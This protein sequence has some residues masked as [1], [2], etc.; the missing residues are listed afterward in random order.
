MDITGMVA[1][2]RLELDRIERSI[3]IL[4]TLACPNRIKRS[5]PKGGNGSPPRFAGRPTADIAARA[6]KVISIERRISRPEGEGRPPMERAEED[7][8]RSLR[9][10]RTQTAKFQQ[11]LSSVIRKPGD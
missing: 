11:A 4:E 6:D 8:S 5:L 1:E 3:L 7:L 9:E 10:L 2:L